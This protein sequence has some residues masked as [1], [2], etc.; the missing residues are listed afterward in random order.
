LSE[1]FVACV[2]MLLSIAASPVI[3]W[4]VS[5]FILSVTYCFVTN[6]V[7]AMGYPYL[8]L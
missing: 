8:Y 5:V 6:I 7:L 1:I 3:L 2:L 4:L